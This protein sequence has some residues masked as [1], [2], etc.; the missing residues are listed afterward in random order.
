MQ[1]TAFEIQW[2][3]NLSGIKVFLTSMLYQIIKPF[4]AVNHYD[5]NLVF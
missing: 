3:P 1:F 5:L 4:G 2:F